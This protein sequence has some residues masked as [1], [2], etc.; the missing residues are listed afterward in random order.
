MTDYIEIKTDNVVE[1]V[2]TG[3]QGAQGI[4]GEAGSDGASTGSQVS[5]D[6]TNLK[7]LSGEDDQT[8]WEQNDTA[9]LN[10]RTTGIR[11]G[12]IVSV[13]GGIGVG[14]TVD[15]TAGA[16]QILNN[17]DASNPTYT[18]I[19]WTAK[20]DLSLSA[21]SP[22]V[23]YWYVDD[24]SDT[25]KQTTTVPTRSQR[26]TRIYLART[27]YTSSI[28]AITGLAS[29]VN[30]VQQEGQ[31][32]KDLANALGAIRASKSD[33]VPTYVGSNLKLKITEGGIF[34]YGSNYDTSYIDP[35]VVSYDEFD[36]SGSDIIRYATP[37]GVIATNLTDIQVSNYAPSGVVTAIPGANTRVGMHFVFRFA[38]SVGN[39]RL[40]YG[41]NYY[42]NASDALTALQTIDPYTLVPTSFENALLLG[43]IIATKTE[44]DLSLATFR[45]TNI[46]GEF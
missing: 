1:I 28:S 23:T 31:S 30:P 18:S 37:S 15:I 22:N 10:V 11:Y 20:T 9:L 32:I 41:N 16:G 46:L 14:D 2:Q 3:A 17:T 6:N 35:H 42:T 38:G 7:V 8:L 40:A 5:V 24:N 45:K 27:S 39:V 13:N 26:R 43:V 4:Q 21:T 44:T 34:D 36:T 12:G 19:T 25:I 33:L 29:E